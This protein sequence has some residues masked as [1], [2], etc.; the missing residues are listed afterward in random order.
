MAMVASVSGRTPRPP[1]R[2]AHPLEAETGRSGGPLGVEADAR[3]AP[4]HRQRPGRAVLSAPRPSPRPPFGPPPGRISPPP[5][6]PV[7]RPPLRTDS[8]PDPPQLPS[9]RPHG[10]RGRGE[11]RTLR[12]EDSLNRLLMAASRRCLDSPTPAPAPAPRPSPQPR[13][14]PE[15]SPRPSD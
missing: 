3:K 8:P 7:R 11:R 2:G 13:Y 1:D 10:L 6:R 9:R 4:G 12:P 14:L 15:A 5:K